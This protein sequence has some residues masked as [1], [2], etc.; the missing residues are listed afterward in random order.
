[1]KN[2]INPK[3]QNW[4]AL[5]ACE[6]EKPVSLGLF[7]LICILAWEASDGTPS[8]K[9][10]I[11]LGSFFKSRDREAITS[12]AITPNTKNAVR[13]SKWEIRY[14]ANGAIAITPNPDPDV[15]IPN[16]SPRFLRNHLVAVEFTTGNTAPVPNDRS[17]P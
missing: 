5:N 16:A 17:K 10:P 15:V 11:S 2:Q 14:V 9:R 12:H 7:S 3:N 1:M 13:Q 6:S 8:G 4:L